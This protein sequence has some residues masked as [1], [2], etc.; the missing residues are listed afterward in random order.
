MAKLYFYYGAM[1]CSKTANALIQ[2]FQ[3]KQSNKSVWLI[4]PAID[5]RD[6]D[7]DENGKDAHNA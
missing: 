5:T 1:G 3:Y 4:K 7:I 2:N 6:D